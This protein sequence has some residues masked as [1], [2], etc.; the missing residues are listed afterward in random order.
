[1]DI[2]AVI[3]AAGAGKRMKSSLPKVLHKIANASFLE[4]ILN[5]L[6]E[7]EVKDI[8]IVASEELKKHKDFENLSHNYKFTVHTQKKRLGTADAL[9]CAVGAKEKKPILVL[10]GDTPFIEEETIVKLA[11]TDSDV[12]CI[13]FKARAP[14]GYGRLI[15]FGDDL[16]EI[17]EEK[18]LTSDQA[19]ITLCNSG[20]YLIQP[21]HARNLLEKVGSNNNAGEFYLTDIIKL[22]H[23][24]GLK[25]SF[26][27]TKE[28]EVLGINDQRQK[29]YAETIM[30]SKLRKKALDAGVTIIS[31]NTVFLS[32]DTKF[33]MDVY[34]HPFV[35]IGQGVEVG[36]NTEILSFS[37]IDSAIIGKNCKIGPYA[38]IRPNTVISEDCRIGNFVE[39]KATK[40]GPGTKASHLSYIGDANIGENVNIGAGTIFCNF[41][42]YSKHIS[43]IGNDTFIGSNVAL[44]APISI[45]SGAIIGAGSVITEDVEDNSLAISR[46][47]QSNY[48]QK[49][50]IIRKNKGS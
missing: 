10:N 38:R 43:N 39:I 23:T 4:I 24:E 36:D 12:V 13:G 5:T 15:T 40:V 20:I 49:A 19:D 25:V 28:R 2:T 22:A 33:G 46:A 26:V 7:L 47:R 48:H 9:K 42:G 37:H 3:L 44:V 32:Y 18:D 27:R 45:G 31:P 34:I 41:D 17:V 16:I 8:R 11:N 29:A 50:D 30:Q 6:K 1:M 14:K 35:V 21:E